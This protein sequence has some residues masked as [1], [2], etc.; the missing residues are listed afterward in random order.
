MEFRHDDDQRLHVTDVIRG[1][2]LAVNRTK[3]ES[4]K[5]GEQRQKTEVPDVEEASEGR[6]LIGS[7][8]DWETLVSRR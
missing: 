1:F 3:L 2:P 4:H 5:P 6:N 8:R 7:D